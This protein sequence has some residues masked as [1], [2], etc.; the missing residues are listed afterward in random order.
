MNIDAVVS[1]PSYGLPP[2][3]KHAFMVERLNQL[4]QFH[5][6]HN[7]IYKHIIDRV[8]GGLKTPYRTISDIPILPVSLFKQRELVS[9][10]KEEIVKV[11]TSSGTTGQTVSKIF[12]DR[13]TA[14]A[15][16]TVLVRIMQHFLG[17]VRW[18][19][20][21]IDDEGV[22]LNRES[23]SAR[24]AGIVGMM[25]FGRNPFFALN[26]DM[27]LR[28]PELLEYIGN[29]KDES[30]L[31]FGF[32]F[33][34]WKYFVS[35]LAERNISVRIPKSTLLHTGGWK[36]LQSEMVSAQVFRNK[37][38]SL[39]GISDI[40][41]YYGMVEQV[42]SIYVEN[43][44]HHMEAS[45]YSDVIIRDPVTLDP[46]SPGKT[47]VI[48][49]VSMLP[50]SYPGHA[51]LTEDLGVIHEPVSAEGSAAFDVLGRVPKAELRGCSDTFII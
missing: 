10:P 21:I 12:L 16:S 51:L 39:T 23:Y 43:T 1:L 17:K 49:V 31:L 6:E 40:R 34:V 22:V 48:E 42:G 36:K 2:K 26:K 18:P 29:H 13:A 33:M 20:I 14:N 37:L 25:Q 7:D 38:H 8:Y 35:I 24:R 45:S 30:I 9:V 28:V 11:L 15:Q 3:E 32:T 5:Y 4:T 41:N 19:M 44:K 50:Q 47:G 27:S 46:V